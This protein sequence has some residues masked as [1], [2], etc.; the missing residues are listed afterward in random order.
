MRKSYN[1]FMATK[2]S[3]N[4]KAKFIFTGLAI[5][6]ILIAVFMLNKIISLQNYVNLV[7][8]KYKI[9]T[10]QTIASTFPNNKGV[11]EKASAA[12]IVWGT[13]GT[14]E[15]G[16]GLQ[17]VLQT[18]Y[19]AD[20][21]FVDKFYWMSSNGK[22]MDLTDESVTLL[23]GIPLKPID[24]NS[25]NPDRYW[26]GKLPYIQNFF[27]ELINY[28][29][30]GGLK[31]NQ[32]FTRME[33]YGFDNQDFENVVSFENSIGT[34]CEVRYPMQYTYSETSRTIGAGSDI[35]YRN[36]AY[37]YVACVNSN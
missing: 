32:N 19:L 17:D 6:F 4:K 27:Q 7:N 30:S 22:E 35:G 21:N 16:F 25:G 13:Y 31:Q 26:P 23:I 9:P 33:I 36:L 12:G 29:K 34:R 20:P 15:Q 8:D 28:L 1:N 37:I 3:N 24:I 11:F 2:T 14:P 5:C 10:D 18:N